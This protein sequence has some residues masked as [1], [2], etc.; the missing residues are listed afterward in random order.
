MRAILGLVVVGLLLGACAG[1]TSNARSS[2]PSVVL[3]FT[4]WA[5]DAKVTN[6]PEPGFRPALTGLTSH[7]IQTAAATLDYSGTSW[8]VN[9]RFTQG[10]AKQFADLTRQNVA[11]C[12]GDPNV[13]ASAVCAGRHLAIWL[14]LTQADIDDWE[15]PTFVTNV[16][17]V[18][19]LSCLQ[20]AAVSTSCPKFVSDP[21]TLDA[22][23]GGEAQ[24]AGNFTQQSANDLATA[25]S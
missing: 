10:G 16:S 14:D 9:I 25:I 23:T 3:V 20:H 11:A 7:D 5:P 15:N 8:V 4:T 13:E 22:I 24:I 18:F 2:R 19:D 17:A 12:P 6:G 21:I 1:T